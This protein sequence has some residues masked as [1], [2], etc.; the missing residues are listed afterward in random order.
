[1]GDIAPRAH[2]LVIDETPGITDVMRE[3]LQEGGYRVSV[4]PTLLEPARLAELAPDVIV[5]ELVFA[6]QVATGWVA[7]R[8][9]QRTPE[10]AQ[11]PVVVC[12]TA[13]EQVR[14]PT[15]AA[16]LKTLGIRVVPKPFLLDDL[17]TA[18]SAALPA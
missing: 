5:Q 1:M 12:T 7:L 18:V 17:L 8:Q 6:R 4:A 13:S 14:E 15:L 2:I 3:V 11:I 10:A 9:M 16:I